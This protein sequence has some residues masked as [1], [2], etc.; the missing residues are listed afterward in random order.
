MRPFVRI[1]LLYV[2][3]GG[4]WII[5]TDA[6]TK[7]LV[8]DPDQNAVLEILHGWAILAASAVVLDRLT[9]REI[10]RREA[11]EAMQRAVEARFAGI[12]DISTDAIISA[13]EEGR[14]VLFNKGAEK[15]FGYR[16]DEVMGKSTNILMPGR[17]VEDHRRSVRRF[18]AGPSTSRQLGKDLDLFGLRKDGIEFPVEAGV[19]RHQEN[20]RTALTAILRDITERKRMES[21]MRRQ[22]ETLK[23]LYDS[24]KSLTRTLNLRE[25]AEGIAEQSVREFGARLA[26]IGTAERDGKVC[27]LYY[28]PPEM[29]YPQ[30]IR[31]RWDDT[32]EGQGPTGRAIRSGVSMVCQDLDAE[33]GFTPW[34]SAA[35]AHGLRSSAAFPLISR[36]R[37]FGSLNLYSDQIGYF[38]AERVGFFEA[39]AHHAAAALENARLIGENERRMRHLH[40]LRTIDMAITA[41]LD[42]RVTLDVFLDQFLA[43]LKVDA[44]AILLLDPNSQVLQFAAGRGFRTVVLQNTRLRLTEG[45]AGRVASERCLAVVPD[46][47]KD[48]GL[49]QR[50]PLLG[51]EEFVSYIGVPLIA[52]GQTKGVLEVFHRAPFDPAQEWIE[53][54]DALATQAAVAIDNSGVFDGLQRSNVELTLAYDTTIEGWSRALDMRDKETEGHCRRVTEMTLALARILLNGNGDLVDIRRGALLHDIGKMGIPDSILLKPGPLSDEEWAIM[55]LHPSY[56]YELLSPIAYLRNALDIPYCHHERWDGAGYPRGLKGEQIPIAARIFAAVDT[57]DALASDRPYRPAWP[58][59]RIRA[60]IRSLSGTHLDPDVVE[61]CL[62]RT[63]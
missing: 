56:A 11:A 12:L 15:I 16:A 45:H 42:L 17:F 60:H 24:A 18:Q 52:K 9:S 47:R 7:D 35:R 27:P 3:L 40:A 48:P 4:I 30:E 54:M 20:G 39:F 53:L 44:A 41:S 26:W 37:P 14:I 43:Q 51:G 34:I 1:S 62:D 33:P 36:G 31:V 28:F 61:V 5:A 29:Q 22:I 55:R 25:L 50:S 21:Q 13:D 63:A 8:P 32:P 2:L 38:T 19:S 57:W 23:T 10:K 49:F 59:D 46:L 6:L 58:E